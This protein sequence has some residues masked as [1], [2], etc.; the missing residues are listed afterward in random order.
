MKNVYGKNIFITGAGS[1]I[2]KEAARLFAESGC[3]VF[4]LS[5]GIEEKTQVYP[6]G[7]SVTG[8]KMDVCSEASVENAVHTV[9]QKCG[10]IDI[11]LHCAGMGISG[12]AEDSFNEDIE[13]IFATNYFGVLRVNRHVLPVMRA[14]K[15][16]LVLIVSSVA[17]RVPIPFQSHYSSTKFALDAYACALRM[18][19][20]EFGVKVC[21]IEP[22]DTKTGFTAARTSA[23][24]DTSPYFEKC[25][26]SGEKM[27]HDE[28]NGHSADRPARI[29]LKLAGKKNP[30]VRKTV[31]VAYKAVM[32][33]MRL[34]PSRLAMT[35]IGMLYVK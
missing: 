10:G 13:K 33:L 27:A 16:G 12:S 24:P 8:V 2:G 30:P 29:A 34:L 25:T 23:M 9:L 7:G 19:I 21:L 20:K 3:N 17:G 14:Q 4:A 6:S 15:H 26:R 11:V 18:E 31:G 35:L 5:R 22:G 1:G 28:Q 32:L